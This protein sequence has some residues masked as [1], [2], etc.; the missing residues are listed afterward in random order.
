VK[1]RD[2]I[3]GEETARVLREVDR[4]LRGLTAAAAERTLRT[5]SPGLGK[6]ESSEQLEE[7]GVRVT[8]SWATEVDCILGC[9]S[10]RCQCDYLPEN[11]SDIDQ[12]GAELSWVYRRAG[13]WRRLECSGWSR[14]RPRRAWQYDYWRIED[15]R[16]GEEPRAAHDG[17]PGAVDGEG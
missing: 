1:P 16:S 2:R 14:T 4:Q 8:R 13:R 5:A 12:N 15:V 17:V 6:G 7:W 9:T 3:S 11:W 10:P